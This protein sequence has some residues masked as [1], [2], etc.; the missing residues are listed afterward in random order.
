MQKKNL[1]ETVLELDLIPLSRYND[2]FEY[3]TVAALRNLIFLNKYGIA[4]KVVRRIG[5]SRMYIKIS[6]LKEWIE[7]TN[8]GQVA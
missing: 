8:G 5:G 3:P 7:E 4:D 1:A 2:V 6:A